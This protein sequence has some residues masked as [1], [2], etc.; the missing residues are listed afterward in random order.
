MLERI[1]GVPSRTIHEVH[2]TLATALCAL[3]KK[4]CDAKRTALLILSNSPPLCEK[5]GGPQKPG[6][7]FFGENL[8]AAVRG[9]IK[10]NMPDMRKCDL[11]I[12]MGTSLAVQ[13]FAGFI[14]KVRGRRWGR[15]WGRRGGGR[16]EGDG[17]GEVRS[18]MASVV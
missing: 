13:P 3:C 1:A 10:L 18:A 14:D 5:C 17:E 4:R 11:L 6:I 8:P 16:K 9:Q 12:V 7:V 2:G 15:R